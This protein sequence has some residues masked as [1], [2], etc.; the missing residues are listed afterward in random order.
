M[1]I[2]FQYNKTSLNEMN[3]QLKTRVRALPTLKSKESALRMEVKKAKEHSES[4][5]AQLEDQLKSYEYMARLWN[6]F[7]PGLISV[8]DVK[9]KTVKIAGVPTP[10]LEEVLFDVKDIN[11]FTKPMWYADGV[12]ILKNLAQLGI[13]SEVYTEVAR[14]LDYQRKKTTQ[15]VNLYEKVQI[16]GYNEAIRKI[17]RYMEDEENLSKASQKI[18]KN[19]HIA[20]EEAEYGN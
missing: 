8:T 10:A 12:Q 14:I 19:K 5:V 7:E 17:K 9:L 13:E 15:K 2:K 18:V 1:A 11:L 3:K 20:E 16:P 6:E 4:L